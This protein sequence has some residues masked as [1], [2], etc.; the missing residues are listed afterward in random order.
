[1]KR[2]ALRFSLFL[3]V[4]NLLPM[5]SVGQEQ[6]KGC[7]FNIVGTW[8]SSTGGQMS[9][10]RQRFGSDGVMTELSRDSSGLAPRLHDGPELIPGAI[11][12]SSL[13]GKV[14]RALAGLVLRC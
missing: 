8:Q 5:A 14:T 7:E 11:L 4:S 9:P 3:V 13:Q 2:F 10:L 1:M 6:Q 12:W